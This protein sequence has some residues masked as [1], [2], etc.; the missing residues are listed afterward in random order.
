MKHLLFL[1]SVPFVSSFLFAQDV[2]LRDY[3][4]VS[5]YNIPKTKI[6]K[7]KYPVIDIHS[8]AYPDTE[9]ELAEW[10][11]NKDM[12]GIEKTI[13]LTGYTGNDFDQAMKSY[14]KHP[15]RFDLWAGLDLS[16]YGKETFIPTVLAELDRCHKAGAKGIGEMT[17]KGQGIYFAFQDNLCD[18]LHL[19]DP[20]MTPIYNKCAELGM[21]LNIHVAEPYWMYLPADEK[22]DGLMNALTWHIDLTIPGM[23][24]HEELIA[25][26]AEAVKNHPKTIFIACHFINCSYDLSIVERLLDAYPNLYIDISA[27]LGETGSISRYM[28]KFITKYADRIFYGTD[29]GTSLDMYQTTFR[30]LETE[31]EHFYIPSF[32]YHW[33][34]SGFGL[35]GKVL[36]KI[37]YQNAKKIL[38]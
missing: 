16:D 38:K 19:N 11:V 10:V 34:Y 4:P 30:F 24:Q 27:R 29:N 35:S 33:N 37:Y 1:L 21:P 18:G 31:D 32:G 36:K 3:A 20:R 12:A 2:L 28:N 14:M 8:H 17:D 23:K 15:G 22:N 5:V 7:A 26:F 9:N 13:V 6:E 25:D